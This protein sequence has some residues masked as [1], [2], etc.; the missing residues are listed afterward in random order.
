[1][2]ILGGNSGASGSGWSYQ[3][4]HLDWA[5]L[6]RDGRAE[7]LAVD[8]PQGHAARLSAVSPR[9]GRLL[10]TAPIGKGSF[11]VQPCP[12]GRALA[13]FDGDQTLDLAVWVPAGSADSEYGPLNLNVVNG[14][15]GQMLWP[16]PSVGVSHPDRRIWPEPAA[17]DLD[18]DGAP[19]VLVTRH[20]GYDQRRSYYEC[21]LSAVDGR[22][23]SV[24][25]TWTWQAG[26]PQIW[27]PV[28][29]KAPSAGQS[30]VCLV[31]QTNSVF[32]L[33]ALDANGQERARRR[34]HLPGRQFDHGR[35]VWRAAD[36]NG[37]GR[38][39]LIF[40]DDGKLCAAGGDALEVKWRWALPHEA[41]RLVEVRATTPGLPPTVVVWSGQETFGL[42]GASGTPQWRA[43]V[44]GEPR[45][46]GSDMPEVCRLDAPPSAAPRLQCVFSSRY[47]NNAA[48][49][50]RQAWPVAPDGHYLAPKPAP[51]KFPSFKEVTLP[52][53][54][55][56]WAYD[57]D[58]ALA[59]SGAIT[60]LSAGLPALLVW[61]AVRRRSW[62]LGLLP[63]GYAG[64]S[65][66]LPCHATLPAVVMLGYSAWLGV[67]AARQ[68]KWLDFSA[69]LV[70]AGLATALFLGSLAPNAPVGEPIWLRSLQMTAAGVP[71]L[72]FWVM[73]GWAIK[74]R[75]W[76]AVRWLLGGSMVAAVLAGAPAVWRDLP[77]RS[78]G[79]TYSWHGAY[80]IWFVGVCLAGLGGLVIMGGQHLVRWFRRRRARGNDRATP[81]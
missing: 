72:A 36:V 61:W 81:V 59:F 69:A 63:L 29:L 71:G 2:D 73:S 44:A 8:S 9:D 31:I 16:A 58:A 24:R 17:A 30:L 64:L 39:E 49:A 19:E 78:P 79:E 23:G 28:A 67:W 68:R 32:T 75:R 21:Q 12:A 51:Q 18:Q 15:T 7:V 52:K 46:G 27:P 41:A 43:S 50:V 13:D 22:R 3:Y 20:S 45:T 74:K 65:W 56:P 57:D 6:D 11:A 38:D 76:S 62:L 60:L 35:F 47:A 70:C 26:H 5:D 77:Y 4:P 34:L 40:L 80:F 37:D 42:D 55:L 53:R 54:P 48:T 33:V 14:R 10:W 25:W 1:L 66:F